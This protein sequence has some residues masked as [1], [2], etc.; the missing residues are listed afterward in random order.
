MKRAGK[1]KVM[2]TIKLNTDASVKKSDWKK[3]QELPVGQY[4]E[5]RVASSGH[6]FKVIPATWLEGKKVYC[7]TNSQ[8]QREITL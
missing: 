1:K 8:H 2:A 3:V 6:I 7:V 5:D 4:P